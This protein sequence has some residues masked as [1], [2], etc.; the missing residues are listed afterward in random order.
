MELRKS[1]RAAAAER[2]ARS[3]RF[4]HSDEGWYFKTREGLTLGPYAEEFDAEISASLLIAS[5]A[6]LDPGGDATATIQ[7]FIRDPANAPMGQVPV[8]D[9]KPINLAAIKRQR[10]LRERIPTFQKAWQAIAG[11][12]GYVRTT[13]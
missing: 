12:C 6:Q 1:D 3:T 11:R 9:K 10:L 8:Q 5:L 7:R 13:L 2:V 4:I